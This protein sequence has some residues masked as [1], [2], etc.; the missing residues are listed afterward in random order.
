MDSFVDLR[1]VERAAA[2]LVVLDPLLS[3]EDALSMAR[4]LSLQPAFK[5]SD[6]EAVVDRTFSQ[7]GRY[8][9][10]PKRA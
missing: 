6:P 2:R 5:V 10:P 9:Q 8:Q 7:A 1:W 4:A 3:L